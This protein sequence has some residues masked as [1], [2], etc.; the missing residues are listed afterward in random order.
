MADQAETPGSVKSQTT[1]PVKT[2]NQAGGH[3]RRSRIYD[4]LKRMAS[5]VLRDDAGA[6]SPTERP[7]DQPLATIKAH[8]TATV[9]CGE[10]APV[11]IANEMATSS[12]DPSPIDE[13]DAQ[14]SVPANEAKPLPATRTAQATPEVKPE[15]TR[16]AKIEDASQGLVFI[17]ETDA[18]VEPFVWSASTPFSPEALRAYAKIDAAEPFKTEAVDHFFRNVTVARDW[19]EDVEQEQVRRFTALRDTLK[20]LLRDITVY[21]FGST[22]IDVFVLGQD[23]SGAVM[24]VH[25]KV[26]E[27]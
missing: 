14:S 5:Q 23:E 7:I 27:T 20:D 8:D 25:T 24:G 13:V 2:A 16:A 10:K 17:S 18:P 6:S 26:V 22:A 12:P 21:R 9:P 19:H 4:L 1:T 3:V 11:V 15:P